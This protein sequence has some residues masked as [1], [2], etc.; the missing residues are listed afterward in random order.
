MHSSLSALESQ[1]YKE[2]NT[3]CSLLSQRQLNPSL[4]PRKEID[5][6]HSNHFQRP[7]SF[8]NK[9][10]I[11]QD[12][13]FKAVNSLFSHPEACLSFSNSFNKYLVSNN[14]FLV[15]GHIAIYKQDKIFALRK[16]H[17][18]LWDWCSKQI[19][20]QLLRAWVWSMIGVLIQNVLKD[21]F[22]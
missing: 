22:P 1:H 15:T 3:S 8:P 10:N 14:T 7:C 6:L 2:G 16:T 5:Q 12:F 9:R 11:G 17:L 18:Y 13:F 19:E 21:I 4:A 20:N